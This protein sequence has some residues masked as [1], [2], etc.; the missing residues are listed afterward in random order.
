MTEIR[1]EAQ[2]HLVPHFT[3]DALGDRVWDSPASMFVHGA[4]FDGH[5]VAT[6]VATANIGAMR[7]EKVFDGV[8]ANEVRLIGGLHGLMEAYERVADV[9]GA[10]Y[11]CAV[12]MTR[13]RSAG[14]ALSDADFADLLPGGLLARFVREACIL[15]RSDSSGAAM[16]AV[17]PPLADAGVIDDLL[18]RVAQVLDRV[19]GRLQAS[20]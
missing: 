9:R 16:L 15:V 6:A 20:K 1:A 2:A 8:R 11:F 10:G 12:E 13:S 14:I 7:D 19:S 5:P 18:A 3:R 17:A 4:T